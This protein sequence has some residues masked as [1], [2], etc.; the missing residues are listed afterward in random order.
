MMR[1]MLLIGLLALA[2]CEV[3]VAFPPAAPPPVETARSCTLPDRIEA[4]AMETV[5]PD[6]VVADRP[7]L[8]HMLAV[9][10]MPET[11]KAGGDGEGDLACGSDNRFGWT[12]CGSVW[13]SIPRAAP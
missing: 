13:S 6:E 11:C 10:W 3:R 4:P 7:I 2:G 5:R 8:F 1:R 9:T 12:P